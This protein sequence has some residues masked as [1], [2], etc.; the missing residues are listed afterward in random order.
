MLAG[1]YLVVVSALALFAADAI[2]EALSVPRPRRALLSAAGAVALWGVTVQWGHPE[3]A[4]AVGLLLFAILALS[5]GRI[6]RSGW[7]L[8]AA[9]ATQP[10]VLLALPVILIV[11]QPRRLAAYW[12]APPPLVCCCW[13]P[14]PRRTGRP[15]STR[16]RSSR[17][18]QPS[19][20]P[21]RGPFSIR[22]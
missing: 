11:I 6:A 1:P 14:P 21:L 19:T 20:T 3:D 4:V 18:G 9:V 2:A 5:R 10:L 15:P 12:C 7:L 22:T 16:S 13:R 17:T 8:G